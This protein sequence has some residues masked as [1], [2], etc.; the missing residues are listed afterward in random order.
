MLAK[1]CA[2]K[3]RSLRSAVVRALVGSNPSIFDFLTISQN[4]LLSPVSVGYKKGLFCNSA[5]RV[6]G[7]LTEVATPVRRHRVRSI[8]ALNLPCGEFTTEQRSPDVSWLNI[9]QLTEPDYNSE[10]IS[11]RPI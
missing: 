3:Y 2:G 7:R 10:L 1:P 11:T 9:K 6:P 8:R 4:R 5:E